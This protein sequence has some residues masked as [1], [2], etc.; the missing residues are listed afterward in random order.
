MKC[1]ILQ[2]TSSCALVLLSTVVLTPAGGVP[3]GLERDPVVSRPIPAR[4]AETLASAPSVTETVAI[5][6][7]GPERAP[8]ELP[9]V[10]SSR[11]PVEEPATDEPAAFR[12]FSLPALPEGLLLDP[13]ADLEDVARH[14]SRR[15]HE[16]LVR[17]RLRLEQWL[18]VDPDQI[19]VSE[20]V[21]PRARHFFLFRDAALV[22]GEWFTEHAKLDEVAYTDPAPPQMFDDAEA[23]GRRYED[24]GTEDLHVELN[25]ARRVWDT[26]KNEAAEEKVGRGEFEPASVFG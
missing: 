15:S 2:A 11:A 24:Y 10:A 4:P 3:G 26:L 21:D 1:P 14:H 12:T 22:E 6:E 8:V 23:R 7:P 19:A 13:E 18:A 5:V 16:E 20:I 9:V 17:T 25:L